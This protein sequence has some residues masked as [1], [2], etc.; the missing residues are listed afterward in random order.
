MTSSP[1]LHH[2]PYDI[3]VGTWIG[4]FAI[5]DKKGEW[6][7]AGASRYLTYWKES[8]TL[9]HFRQDEDLRATGYFRVPAVEARLNDLLGD[10]APDALLNLAV[11]EYDLKVEG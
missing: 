8:P 9:M 4:T 10:P 1:L 5:F 11:P 6:V 7:T 3:M 2:T